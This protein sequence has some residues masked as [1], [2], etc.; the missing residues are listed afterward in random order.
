MMEP[1]PPLWRRLA[2]TDAPLVLYGTGNGADKL[3]AAL[4]RVGRRPDGVF[5]SDG[6][7]RQRTCHGMPVLSYDAARA[8]FGDGMIVLVAFGS[9]LPEVMA[10]IDRL[11]AA[12]E[13]YLPELPLVGGEIFDEAYAAAHRAELDAARALF[14]EPE[15]RALFD[16][17]IAYRLSGRV[18]LLRRTTPLCE[19]FYAAAA[20]G[21]VTSALDGGAYVGDTARALRAAYPCLTSLLAVEPDP[22]SFRRLAAYAA[23]T[24]GVVTPLHGAL[25]DAAGTLPFSGGGSRASGAYGAARPIEVPAL[26]V[27]ELAG[28]APPDLIKLDVEGGEARA[29]NGARETICSHTPALVVSL[30]H[31]TEDLFSLPLSLAA[32]YPGRYDFRL[33]RAPCCPAWDLMLCAAPRFGI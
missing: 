8:R 1:F 5:A 11:A 32:A 12:H 2:E 33:R 22:R 3:I 29:L 26:T 19:I 20:P 10:R 6:F 28:G 4:A 17:M 21:T 9:A 30:Y 23:E 7:V 16:E 18:E 25:W 13:L 31:R 14:T 15:S 24:A 27:D